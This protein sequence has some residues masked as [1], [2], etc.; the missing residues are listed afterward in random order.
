[1]KDDTHFRNSIVRFGD[2][3]KSGHEDLILTIKNRKEKRYEAHFFS[4][5]PCDPDFD[6]STLPDVMKK[7]FETIKHYASCVIFYEDPFKDLFS[8]L[9]EHETFVTAFFDFGEFG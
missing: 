6:D 5:V 7:T 9:I 2:L 1:M 4:N 3:D 8:K